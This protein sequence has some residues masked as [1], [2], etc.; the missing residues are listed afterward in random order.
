MKA[1]PVLGALN[2]TNAALSGILA[3]QFIGSSQ[4]LEREW[5][6]FIAL[7][8]IGMV[9][10]GVRLFIRPKLSLL[11]ASGVVLLL[12]LRAVMVVQIGSKDT[13][14]M[15]G[16]MLIIFGLVLTAALAIVPLITLVRSLFPFE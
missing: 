3:L 1:H 11:A 4:P 7:A 15:G 12:I 13:Q 5:G 9:A 8:T 2:L 14:S 6:I 10:A 16:G